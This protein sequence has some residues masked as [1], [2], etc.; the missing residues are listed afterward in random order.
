MPQPDVIDLITAKFNDMAKGP[1]SVEN[2]DACPQAATCNT[3]FPITPPPS[4]I[5]RRSWGHFV[6]FAPQVQPFDIHVNPSIICSLTSYVTPIPLAEGSSEATEVPF[7]H[8]LP[9]VVTP[10][11]SSGATSTS[12]ARDESPPCDGVGLERGSSAGERVSTD[13]EK[14]AMTA[15]ASVRLLASQVSIELSS[16]PG[17]PALIAGASHVFVRAI[18]WPADTGGA[19]VSRDEGAHGR[20]G[21]GGRALVGPEVF[22]RLSRVTCGVKRGIGSDGDATLREDDH[23]GGPCRADQQGDTILK[24]FDI[25]AHLTRPRAASG[26]AVGIASKLSAARGWHAGIYVDELYLRFGAV[27]TRSLEILANLF[28]P[29]MATA[30]L[31]ATKLARGQREHGT[32]TGKRWQNR[33]HIGDLR[34]LGRVECAESV[35]ETTVTPEPGE[36]VF[37]GVGPPREGQSENEGT[38]AHTSAEEVADGWVHCCE[39][40]YWGLRRVAQIALPYAPL[41]GVVPLLEGLAVDSLEVELSFMDP[42][43]QTLEVRPAEWL[44][45]AGGLRVSRGCL[46]SALHFAA[47]RVSV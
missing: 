29:A 21:S 13:F 15:S 41:R 10:F 12:A 19:T 16:Y 3:V 34:A 6:F 38:A 35:E 43:T 47:A 28:F 26:A 45:G 24:P 40:R 37:Y 27:H 30:S 22:A 31:T 5:P 1:C 25:D 8:F 42:L 20:A 18:T 4:L 9:P 23:P 44:V 2:F 46:R 7:P 32:A 39:W 33:G 14:S 17:G 36:A 11:H